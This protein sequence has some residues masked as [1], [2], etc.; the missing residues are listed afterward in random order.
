MFARL[1]VFLVV[2]IVL[3]VNLYDVSQPESVLAAAAG[4]V[5]CGSMIFFGQTWAD[6][7]LPFGFWEFFASDSGSSGNSAP[8]I[9][10]MGWISVALMGFGVW[11]R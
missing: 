5:V 9:A 4:V 1:T 11:I 7:I 8:A 10:F 6:Y 3:I 2:A